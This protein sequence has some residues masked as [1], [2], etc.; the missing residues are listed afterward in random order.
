M[1]T[2]IDRERRQLLVEEVRVLAE[3]CKVHL[4]V[5]GQLDLLMTMTLK[6]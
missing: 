3:E 4:N 5:S 1:L 6:P 2:D